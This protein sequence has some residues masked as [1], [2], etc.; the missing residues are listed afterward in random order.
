M[1]S[2][3]PALHPPDPTWKTT[4]HPSTVV[5][6]F[7]LPVELL[8]AVFSR[9]TKPDVLMNMAQVCSHW[10]TIVFQVVALGTRLHHARPHTCAAGRTTPSRTVRHAHPLR[11][12]QIS[13]EWSSGR[14]EPVH[15]CSFTSVSKR[16]L[17]SDYP[18]R[19]LTEA[20]TTLCGNSPRS[21]EFLATITHA[22]SEWANVVAQRASPR[23][24]RS[25]TQGSRAPHGLRP[26]LDSLRSRSTVS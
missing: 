6:A 18:L 1:N 14:H 20:E 3:G 10:K 12:A 15:V 22:T 5:A 7:K 25:R 24:C 8:V 19:S 9:H 21:R 13:N 11:R 2:T 16:W 23:S 17:S 4:T 26:R